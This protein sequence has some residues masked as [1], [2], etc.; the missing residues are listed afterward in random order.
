M[1]LS[2]PEKGDAPG[3]Y[4][5]V[6]LYSAVIEHSISTITP[7]TLPVQGSTTFPRLI[8]K[9]IRNVLVFSA[10]SEDS[11]SG[12][13]NA[14][15]ALMQTDN[16]SVTY[17]SYGELSA[18]LSSNKYSMIAFPG[19]DG[20]C[21]Q[22]VKKFTSSDISSVRTFVNNGGFFLGICMGAAI[23]MMG[24][25][26][27]GFGMTCNVPGL[28]CALNFDSIYGFAPDNQAVTL[29]DGRKYHVYIEDP[30]NFGKLKDGSG[31][32]ILGTYDSTSTTAMFMQP[33]GKGAYAITSFHPEAD[34]SWGGGIKDSSAFKAG[35][36][37]VHKLIGEL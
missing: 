5:E 25:D 7:I 16:W 12:C 35:I 17:A 37:M 27:N 33:F 4:S 31:V 2:N 15:A 23:A 3:S 1:T 28:G 21:T 20:E 18:A 13:A 22:Y 6:W 10:N 9:I 29:Q 36:F 26:I 14:L 11:V 8:K 24:T 32:T 19:A 34:R 30:P